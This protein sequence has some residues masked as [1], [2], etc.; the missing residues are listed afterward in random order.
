[1]ALTILRWPALID[2]R[3]MIGV[4]ALAYTVAHIIFYFGL[5][6]WDFASIASESVTRLTLIVAWLSTVGLIVLGATS[7]DAAIRRM[8]ARSWQRLHN[9]NY[10]ITGLAVF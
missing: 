2:V 10:A 3:R 6:S 5:R 4:T 8:G 9:L 7:L 1:P